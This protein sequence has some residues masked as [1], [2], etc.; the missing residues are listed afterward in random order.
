MSV[1]TGA[2]GEAAE[3][4]RRDELLRGVGEDDVDVGAGLRELAGDIGGLVAGDAAADAEDDAR[5][6][7]WIV[8]WHISRAVCSFRGSGAG[9]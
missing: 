4:Q 6:A 7:K 8:V 2:A 9:R 3:R 5:A 1:K